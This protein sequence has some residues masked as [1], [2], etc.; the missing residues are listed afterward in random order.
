LLHPFAYLLLQT[1]KTHK[2]NHFWRKMVWKA[3]TFPIRNDSS[4]NIE[5]AC[6][7]SSRVLWFWY[8][9]LYHVTS[10]SIRWSTEI[11]SIRQGNC[12]VAWLLT[13]EEYFSD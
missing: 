11:W 8:G 7:D 9:H 13:H 2:E 10:P 4:I 6:C 3:L 12:E 5:S 1:T